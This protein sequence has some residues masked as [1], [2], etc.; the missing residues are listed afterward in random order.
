V[1][2][3]IKP[4][5]LLANGDGFINSHTA[6]AVSEEIRRIFELGTAEPGEKRLRLFWIYG[7]RREQ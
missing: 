5:R 4:A 3:L 7:E 6:N 2:G 1:R